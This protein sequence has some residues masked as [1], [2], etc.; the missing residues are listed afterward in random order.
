M[1]G[2]RLISVLSLFTPYP[3]PTWSTDISIPSLLGTFEAVVLSVIYVYAIRKNKLKAVLVVYR[4]WWV[5]GL[6]GLSIIF[7][8]ILVAGKWTESFESLV[9]VLIILLCLGL[10]LGLITFLWWTGL[11]G[12]KRIVETENRS[13]KED[14]PKSEATQI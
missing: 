5:L 9:L 6:I 11:R 4:I 12:L 2:Y 14:L 7:L 10:P 8:G 13:S 1:G 3:L